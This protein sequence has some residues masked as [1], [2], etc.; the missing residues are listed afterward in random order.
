MGLV[1]CSS[2]IGLG[3]NTFFLVQYYTDNYDLIIS[4]QEEE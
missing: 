3:G 2:H 1:E 4:L